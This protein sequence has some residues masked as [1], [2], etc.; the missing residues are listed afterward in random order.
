MSILQ[1]IKS[2]IQILKL[3]ISGLTM[4][5]KVVENGVLLKTKRLQA[6]LKFATQKN[7]ENQGY[8][9]NIKITNYFGERKKYI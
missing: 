6:A 3:T 5:C 4:D 2:D 9:K 1:Q 7:P 8:Y